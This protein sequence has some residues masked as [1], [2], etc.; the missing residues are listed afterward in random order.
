M[1]TSV[2][3]TLEQAGEPCSAQ[4]A[5]DSV[6]RRHTLAALW[7]VSGDNAMK[8]QVMNL[9]HE[10][11]R[12]FG[13]EVFDISLKDIERAQKKADGIASMLKLGHLRLGLV[14]RGIRIYHRAAPVYAIAGHV[15]A[16]GSAFAGRFGPIVSKY[17]IAPHGLSLGRAAGLWLAGQ[18]ISQLYWD[19]EAY[20]KGV[21][22]SSTDPQPFDPLFDSFGL[23]QLRELSAY[24]QIGAKVDW[25]TSK[26]RA[27][28]LS[29]LKGSALNK[30]LGMFTGVPSYHS[31]LLTLCD[32]VAIH[33][34][35]SRPR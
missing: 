12:L 28:I 4:A 1:E 24:L 11:A 33:D 17:G 15:Y 5:V 6:I 18:I 3:E 22:R 8:I 23:E 25:E 31:M 14:L 2:T 32:E 27:E 35:L 7:P 34:I 30:V 29:C 16:F 20:I 19:E 26:L 9:T 10:L 21:H 13:R